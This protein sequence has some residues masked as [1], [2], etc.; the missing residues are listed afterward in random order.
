MK[1]ETNTNN[2][3]INL[4]PTQNLPQNFLPPRNEYGGSYIN[5]EKQEDDY[6]NNQNK[7]KIKRERFNESLGFKRLLDISTM[8]PDKVILILLKESVLF[9]KLT[10]E[11][12]TGD[13]I[14]LIL[15]IVKNVCSTAYTSNVG[16]I[17]SML[18][19]QEFVDQLKDYVSQI[20]QQ[21]F[22]DKQTN[23]YLWSDVNQ[24][25]N[26]LAIFCETLF[27]L[28]PNEACSVL[29]KLLIAS[30]MTISMFY[31]FHKEE[32]KEDVRKRFEDLQMKLI[33]SIQ[34]RENME[35]VRESE[36]VET[37]EPPDDFR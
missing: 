19:H 4:N 34:E 1:K 3:V 31:V 32:I 21:N 11:K 29:P 5:D 15:R 16:L 30:V 10:K 35:V 26:N 9:D 25:W 13:K 8:D 20:N 6:P 24:F 22:N 36:D 7:M 12:L 18:C 28:K 37:F 14:I 33:L 27:R 2:P 17:L 23:K